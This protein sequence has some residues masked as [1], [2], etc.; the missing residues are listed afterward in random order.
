MIPNIHQS[1]DEIIK[2]ANPTQKLL[3]QQVRLIVGENSAV[4]QFSYMGAI[5]GSEFLTYSANKLYLALE[6]WM[7]HGNISVNQFVHT[8]YDQTNTVSYIDSAC[9]PYYDGTAAAVRYM[10]ISSKLDNVWF[11]RVATTG[12]YSYM[13]FLGYKLTM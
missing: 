6:L 9:M 7:G 10:P 5:A 2:A 3:W 11:S 13:K 12:L 1:I 4:Q 8:L